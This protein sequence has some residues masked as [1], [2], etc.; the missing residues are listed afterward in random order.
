MYLRFLVTLAMPNRDQQLLKEDI[1]CQSTPAS[2]QLSM[3][4]M[5][6]ATSGGGGIIVMPTRY[7]V[8]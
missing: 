1:P 7:T 2:L 4:S 8:P 3:N 6:F 5:L